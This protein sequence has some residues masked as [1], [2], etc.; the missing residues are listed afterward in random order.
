MGEKIKRLSLN[1]MR[2]GLRNYGQPVAIFDTGPY[3]K[4]KTGRAII[5][6]TLRWLGYE[7]EVKDNITFYWFF[8]D[9]QLFAGA[10]D[11]DTNTIINM[12]RIASATSVSRYDFY[13][14]T[15]DQ[16]QEIEKFLK[17]LLTSV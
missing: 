17:N 9:N 8:Y 14:L 2:E 5:V 10:Y 3:F 13:I 12:V 7:D 4:T 6:E 11:I 15:T 16:M 1:Q